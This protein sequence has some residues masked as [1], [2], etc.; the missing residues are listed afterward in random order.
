MHQRVY[1]IRV[2]KL[3]QML[4]KAVADKRFGQARFCL[5]ELQALHAQQKASK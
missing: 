3:E 2:A 4:A 1:E 5:E